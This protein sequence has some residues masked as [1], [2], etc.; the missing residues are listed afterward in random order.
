MDASHRAGE[1]RRV[2]KSRGSRDPTAD[3]RRVLARSN[4]LKPAGPVKTESSVFSV[5]QHATARWCHP[6]TLRGLGF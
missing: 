6:N 3:Y 1:C 2:A 4:R 5:I